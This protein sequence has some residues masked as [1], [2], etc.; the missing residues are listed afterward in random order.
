[1]H[2]TF[3]KRVSECPVCEGSSVRR[4]RRTGFVER[5]WFRLAFVWPYRCDDCD[6]RFWGFQRSYPARLLGP[7]YLGFVGPPALPYSHPVRKKK[8]HATSTSACTIADAKI[9]PVCLQVQ[10]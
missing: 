4:S 5:I 6:S 2:L 10:P 7:T 3:A 9:D 1:M 8:C